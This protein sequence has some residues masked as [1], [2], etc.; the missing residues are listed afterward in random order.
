MKWKYPRANNYLSYQAAGEDRCLISDHSGK[1]VARYEVDMDTARFLRRLD[2]KTPPERCL[3][4]ASADERKELLR[5]LKRNGLLRT[6]G[7][8]LLEGPGSLK[9]TLWIPGSKSRRSLPARWW[10]RILLISWLPVFCMGLFLFMHNRGNYMAEVSHVGL[11]IAGGAVTGL[12]AGMLLHELSHGAAAL[13]YGVKVFEFG[14]FLEHFMPGAYTA[15][16]ERRARRRWHRIQIDGAGVEANL[17]TTGL[18]L[19][20]G[21]QIRGLCILFLMMAMVNLMLGLTNLCFWN[22]LDGMFLFSEIIGIPDFLK[23]ASEVLFD[24]RR[25]RQIRSEMGISGYALLFTFRAVLGIQ[26]LMPAAIVFNL[27]S[28]GM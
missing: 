6:Y 25:K 7:R 15:I 10:N 12:L 5:R 26:L 14:L 20:A 17:W 13:S 1:K 19:T 8:L 27:L 3:P 18:C 2:G 24:R 9:L 23:T 4:D 22:G 16:D 28:L 11:Q 21:L